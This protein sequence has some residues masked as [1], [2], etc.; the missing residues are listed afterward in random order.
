MNASPESVPAT[1]GI[2]PSLADVNRWAWLPIPVLMLAIA[3]LWFADWRTPYEAPYLFAALNVFFSALVALSAVLFGRGFLVRGTPSLL[4][5]GCGAVVS[6]ASGIKSVAGGPGFDINAFITFHNVY[7]WESSLCYLAAAAFLMRRDSPVQ[8]RGLWLTAGYALALITIAFDFLAVRLEWT[9]LFFVQGAGGTEARQF[10][11]AS[12]IATFILTASLLWRVRSNRNSFLR[13]FCF[14]LLLLAVG[15]FGLM[16]QPVFGGALGWVSR[17][18]HYL[19][20]AYLFMAAL[21]ILRRPDN[22]IWQPARRDDRLWQFYGIAIAAVLIAAVLRTV[23]LH[24]LDLR[25]AYLTFYPAV[26][27]AAIYGGLR[28]GTLATFLSV[29]VVGSY[30]VDPIGLATEKDPADWLAIA[31]FLTTCL[32]LSWLAQRTQQATARLQQAERIRRDELE[33]EVAER[34]AELTTE[35]AIRRQIEQGLRESEEKFRAVFELSP[36]AKVIIELEDGRIVDVNKAWLDLLGFTD[37]EVIGRTLAELGI[38]PDATP[39]SAIYK[40]VER[41][42]GFRQVEA[43]LRTKEGASI[44]ALVSGAQMELGGK[45]HLIG[46]AIDVSERKKSEDRQ[47]LLMREVDHRAKN[48]LAVVQAL[49]RLTK[50]PTIEAFVEAVQGRVAALARA[51]SLLAPTRWSGASLELLISEEFAAYRHGRSDKICISGPP[52]RVATEAVQSLGI[53]FHELTTNAA[54]YGALSVPEGTVEVRWGVSEGGDLWLV[55]QESGGPAVGEPTR[56]GFGSTMISSAVTTQLGGNIEFR[57]ESRGLRCEFTVGSDRFDSGETGPSTGASMASPVASPLS[58]KG[59]CV[60][61]VE[62][63][64]LTATGTMEDLRRIGCRP[65]GPAAT[66]DDALRLVASESNLDAAVIDINLRG[67]MAWPV[68]DALRKRGV[69]F[70]LATGYGDLAERGD[71]ALILEKPFSI[72]R[73]TSALQQIMKPQE[74]AAVATEL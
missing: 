15:Q 42:Q 11:M 7:V 22:P 10:V 16:L 5:F 72:E 74:A 3:G 50:A 20:G 19:G 29:A 61:V 32:M 71:D 39:P 46:V 18:A 64:A 24:G 4:L 26:M 51:H 41:R 14:F 27:A 55:W 21:A 65:V 1:V 47:R 31:V 2:R 44:T 69:P 58:L 52:L 17:F 66:L 38:R 60:L 63:E 68:A 30:W 36:V 62:D 28:A 13:W 49:V 54:K 9:P 35:I 34:T 59:C 8:R 23:F 37:E 67:R 48:A 6:S 12:T 57:W 40:L 53:V 56:R 33:R 43:T 70:L 45:A 73:L 25:F